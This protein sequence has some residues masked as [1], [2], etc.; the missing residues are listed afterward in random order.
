MISGMASAPSVNCDERNVGQIKKCAQCSTPARTSAAY[1]FKCGA[2]LTSTGTRPPAM[3]GKWVLFVCIA[4]GACGAGWILLKNQRPQSELEPPAP[5]PKLG[6]VIQWYKGLGL[7][8]ATKWSK[9]TPRLLTEGREAWEEAQRHAEIDRNKPEFHRVM[10]IA[11]PAVAVLEDRVA[12][13][14]GATLAKT[15][16]AI[17]TAQSR[18]RW[19]GAG[20]EFARSLLNPLDKALTGFR[21]AEDRRKEADRVYATLRHTDMWEQFKSG[22][23]YLEYQARQEE[24][25]ALKAA[26][27]FLQLYRDAEQTYGDPG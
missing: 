19:I 5:Q 22:H 23:E 7:E 4:T 21:A 8:F 16:D 24:A 10:R 20:S 12:G 25:T 15:C 1:C 3:A 6:E 14:W 17:E 26:K 13:K 9:Q 18:L 11:K 2:R 27:T